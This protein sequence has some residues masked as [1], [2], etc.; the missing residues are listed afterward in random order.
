MADDIQGTLNEV[1][2]EIKKLEANIGIAYALTY[3]FGMTAVMFFASRVA[4]R[5]MGV[6]LKE[7]ARKLKDG[8]MSRD[9]SQEDLELKLQVKEIT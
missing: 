4:P 9:Q 7:E 8:A 5:L 6:D 1:A 2:E 3:L